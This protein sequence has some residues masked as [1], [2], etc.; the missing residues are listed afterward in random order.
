VIGLDKQFK[1]QNIKKD[2]YFE[3][4]NSKV[5]SFQELK[6]NCTNVLNVQQ[7]NLLKVQNFPENINYSEISYLYLKPLLDAYTKTI[8]NPK[9]EAYT[10]GWMNSILSHIFKAENGF[11]VE[12]QSKEAADGEV[13][14]LVKYDD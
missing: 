11:L 13:D 1:N 7:K 5:I 10:Y 12:P 3:W 14:F 2:I 8:E 4:L 6:G 9:I